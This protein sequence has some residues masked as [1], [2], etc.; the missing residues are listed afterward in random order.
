MMVKIDKIKIIWNYLK[1]S[2]KFREVLIKIKEINITKILINFI[3]IKG[4]SK[5]DNDIT[6]SD[7]ALNF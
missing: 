6:F 3:K 4:P 7:N 5:T 2:T 1:A